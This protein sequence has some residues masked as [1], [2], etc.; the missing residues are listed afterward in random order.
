MPINGPATTANAAAPATSATAA[1][2]P[3]PTPHGAALIAF[4]LRAFGGLAG[5]TRGGFGGFGAFVAFTTLGFG[6]FVGHLMV[7][8]VVRGVADG[9]G[10]GWRGCFGVG[11]GSGI[12]LTSSTVL[13]KRSITW[14]VTSIQMP[15]L[16]SRNRVPMGKRAIELP[17]ILTAVSLYHIR[18]CILSEVSKYVKRLAYFLGCFPLLF[19]R[20][21]VHLG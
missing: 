11:A 5:R 18:A 19:E 17:S 2:S 16:L 8:R 12:T 15:K 6:L 13:P 10:F 20:F 9:V 7:V 21:L 1:T 4:V 14:A 3:Q